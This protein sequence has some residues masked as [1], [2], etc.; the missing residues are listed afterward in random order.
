MFS[1]GKKTT[2]ISRRRDKEA[3]AYL[4]LLLRLLCKHFDEDELR[5]I[6]FEL[7]VNYQDLPGPGRAAKMEDLL[8]LQAREG[9]VDALVVVCREQRELV[10]WPE[11]PESVSK[12]DLMLA[13]TPDQPISKQRRHKLMLLERVYKFWI[14]GVFANSVHHQAVIELNKH[15][16]ETAVA[17]DNSWQMVLAMP[18]DELKKLPPDTHI[19]DVFVEMD[20][21]LL[22][23]GDPGAGKTTTLLQL[24]NELIE[25]ARLNPDFPI[26][27]IFSL[28]TWQGEPLCKWLVTELHKRYEIRKDAAREWVDEDDLLLLLDGLDEVPIAQQEA[29]IAAINEF[30]AEHGFTGMAVCSRAHEYEAL[31]A[32]LQFSG[33]VVLEPLT[34]KQVG[35]YLSKV[36]PDSREL[37]QRILKDAA[38]KELTKSPLML[39]VMSVAYADSEDKEQQPL[40]LQ[41]GRK[42]LFDTYVKQMLA[43]GSNQNQFSPQQTIIWLNNLAQKLCQHNK[44]VFFMEEM[45]R[46]WLPKKQQRLHSLVVKAI[47]ILLFAFAAGLFVFFNRFINVENDETIFD[48]ILGATT[49]GIFVITVAAAVAMLAHWLPTWLALIITAVAFITINQ[50]LI[51]VNLMFSIMYGLIAGG[52]AV[53]F[54]KNN[55]IKFISVNFSSRRALLGIILAI[56]GFIGMTQAGDNAFWSSFTFALFFIGFLSIVPL[57]LVGRN[58]PIDEKITPNQSIRKSS[59]NAIKVGGLLFLMILLTT[60]LL[61]IILVFVITTFSDSN[62]MDTMIDGISVSLLFGLPLALIVALFYGGASSIQHLILRFQLSRSG[63]LPW[64]TISFLNFTTRCVFM[65]QIG[66]GYIYIHRLFLEYFAQ[67]DLLDREF[68]REIFN[69]T[70]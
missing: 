57:M 2:Y 3:Q 40:A 62:Y 51:P 30:R 13:A 20:E 32:R 70:T 6:C 63:I 19:V 46:S 29:C 67:P 68:V 7:S 12:T 11:R 42:Q 43:R 60:W 16:L 34:D 47:I 52:T 28:S 56:I 33:A 31:T 59:R 27:V 61:G 64:N 14:E 41:N 21:T 23:L 39:S 15:S 26:P 24:A 22:V 4:A 50:I 69:E 25:Q 45:Q 36:V 65:Q 17:E 53:S 58:D 9:H 44:T 38:L 8:K 66:G 55:Q 54:T 37:H 18:G 35:E 10:A 5:V 48:I 49:Q 1:I